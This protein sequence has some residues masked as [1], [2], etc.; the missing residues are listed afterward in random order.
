M[1][2]VEEWIIEVKEQLKGFCVEKDGANVL[3]ASFCLIG[4]AY[5]WRCTWRI[6][7]KECYILEE[8]LKA[9][10]FRFQMNST[11]EEINNQEQQRNFRVQD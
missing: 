3:F 1:K 7:K 5:G 11:K 10:H 2:R 8:F 4:S 9:I 6:S